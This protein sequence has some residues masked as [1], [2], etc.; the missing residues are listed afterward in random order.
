M[1]H[2]VLTVL[3]FLAILFI[4][5]GIFLLLLL[6][7]QSKRNLAQ[8]SD[9]YL[10]VYASQSGQ[11]E[12][13]AL[14]TAQQLSVSGYL[15]QCLSIEQVNAALFKHGTKILWIVSTYGE[16]DAPDSARH[17][18]KNVMTKSFDLNDIEYA[19]LAFGDS[20]YANFCNFG[21]QL[22]LWL[23]ENHAQ[24]LFSLVCVDQLNPTMGLTE[25][26]TQ[27]DL[28]LP[29]FSAQPVQLIQHPFHSVVLSERHLLNQGSLGHPMYHL[30]FTQVEALCWK[31][32]DI[33]EIQ[34]ANT[35]SQIKDFLDRFNLQDSNVF[36]ANHPIELLRFKNLRSFDAMQ[37]S[38]AFE[39]WLAQAEDL[40]IREYSIASITSQSQ[41]ELVVRR[42][43]NQTGLGLGSG[44]LTHA[45]A[46]GEQ[47]SCRVRSNPAFYLVQNDQPII[48][49][50]NGSGIAGLMSHIRQRAEWSFQQN[51]L[52]YGERQYQ[53][54]LGFADQLNLWQ[55]QSVL[56]KIDYAF[57]RDTD[58]QKYVQDCVLEKSAQLKQWIEQGA[59]IYI[60]GSLKGMAQGVETV[61]INILGEDQFEQLIEQK[62]YL[63]DVY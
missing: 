12:S 22:D 45:L 9:E 52:I 37:H 51:W 56:P 26:Q 11:T 7:P 14:Q 60:C 38:T 35:D 54:D 50:G 17:F 33:L 49:I 62:R 59:S 8:N 41:I 23:T 39:Q 47:I 55:Q 40:P 57:S 42:E 25:W 28:V 5:H 10:I 2:A 27:L 44:Y 36:Q 19:V 13:F 30:V 48:L 34:C 24:A 21:K 43:V 63:R 53:V 4:F 29:Q 20:H 15:V 31:S 58:N 1:T 61:L 3:I 6:R 32:G 16:G 46:L 18:V